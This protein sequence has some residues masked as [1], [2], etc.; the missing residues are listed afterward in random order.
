MNF[1]GTGPK[2]LA[3]I[4]TF[5][6]AWS[7]QANVWQRISAA[8]SVK[9]ARKM[10]LLSFTLVHL[11]VSFGLPLPLPWELHSAQQI[12]AGMDLSLVVYVI[13]S[14]VTAPDYEKADRFIRKA[15]E[16]V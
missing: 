2:Y 7:I 11:A 12:T 9:D 10:T 14:L 16:K 3:Y 4:F 8:R 1:W 6:L 15:F 5:S 13:A